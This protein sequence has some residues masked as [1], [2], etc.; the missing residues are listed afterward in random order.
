MSKNLRW[1]AE[2]QRWVSFPE[3][4]GGAVSVRSVSAYPVRSFT[5]LGFLIVLM[6]T[7]IFVL[8]DDDD[9]DDKDEQSV[10]AGTSEPEENPP[11]SPPD[12][13]PT[14]GADEGAD[15]GG[16]EEDPAPD[17]YSVWEDHQGFLLHVPE[18]WSREEEPPEDGVFKVFFTPDARRHFI[19]VR[20][21]GP[22]V[23]SP[24]RA[25]DRLEHE[26]GSRPEFDREDQDTEEGQEVDEVLSY[27]YEHDVHGPFQVFARALLG[28]DGE[29]YAIL[30]AGPEPEYNGVHGRFV[31]SAYSFRA[32]GD[33]RF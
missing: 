18:R 7:A 25:L 30:S 14:L 2:R 13:V 21:F 26:A 5:V 22:D 33:D 27:R 1:D 15:E 20:S 11:P 8:P 19:Q 6:L 12:D 31:G 32:V 17:G 16:G 28:E 23:T 3:P 10:S 29:V 9:E 4:S 24:G